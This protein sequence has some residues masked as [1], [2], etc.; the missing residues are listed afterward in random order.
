MDKKKNFNIPFKVNT[1]CDGKVL[2]KKKKRVY[3][4][5]SPFGVGIIRGINFLEAKDKIKDLKEGEIVKVEILELENEKG[6]VELALRDSLKKD[7]WDNIKELKENNQT[8]S[9]LI[10]DANAGGLIGKFESLVGFLPTSQM[11]SDHY[12]KV[13]DGDRE[14]ILERLKEFVGQKLEVKVLDFDPTTNKLI[15]SE[16]LIELEKNK[17]L[18]REGDIVDVIVTK[19]VDFGVFVKIKD[20]GI[21]GLVHI[22]EII[23]NQSP[24]ELK[25]LVKE[26]E[27]R[28]AKIIRINNGRIF[29]S[30]KF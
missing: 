27:E 17:D 21:D 8:L 7:S 3:I 13:E 16:K 20:K 25:N 5:L 26:N 29:L 24:T 28:K 19:V 30:F 4:D 2:E 12:P 6:F 10:T 11:S 9:I 18:V 22:S 1:I 14:K 23:D 15:F